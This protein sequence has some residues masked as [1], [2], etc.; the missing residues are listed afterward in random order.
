MPHISE[1]SIVPPLEIE[2]GHYAQAMRSAFSSM[3][4]EARKA[5]GLNQKDFAIAV[6]SDKSTVGHYETGYSAPDLDVVASWCDTLNLHGK[7]RRRFLDLAALAHLPAQVRPQFEAWYEEHQTLKADY[8]DL[9]S[10]V[11]RVADK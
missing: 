3:M 1:V 11:R 7:D 2:A 5:I 9:I 10:Q 8:A 6:K 4:A